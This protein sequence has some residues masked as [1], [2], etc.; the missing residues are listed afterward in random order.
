MYVNGMPFL[1]TI[2]KN[3]KYRTAM[4]VANWMAPTISNL[5]ESVLKLYHKASFQ[6]MGVCADHEFKPGLHVLQDS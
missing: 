2:S 6:V 1:T 3:I 5:V 4:W